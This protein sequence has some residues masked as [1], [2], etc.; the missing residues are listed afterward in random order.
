MTMDPRLQAWLDGDIELE[1][2]PETLREEAHAWSEF[3]G[4]ARTQ[5]VAGAPFGATARVMDAIRA[6]VANGLGSRAAAGAAWLLRP[7]AVRIPPLAVA[8][9]IALVILSVTQLAVRP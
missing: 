7:R 5:G 8:A 3:L 6:D 4:S 1:A 2:L 9:A